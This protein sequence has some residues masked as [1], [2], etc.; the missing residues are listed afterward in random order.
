VIA[1]GVD[2]HK[3][4]H[5]AVALDQ[6]GHVL[7]KWKGAN[8]PRGWGSFL[9]W[10]ASLGPERQVGIEG[11][12]N[13]GRGLAQFLVERGESVF[14]VNSRWTALGR[15]SARSVGKSDVLD[16]NAVA[17]TVVREAGTLPRVTADDVTVIL[18]L[19][20]S[21]RESAIVEA[22]RLRNQI[23]SLLV[24]IDP[25]YE[26]SLPT[27]KTKAGLVAL[28]EYVGPPSGAIGLE[29]AA[30]VRRLAQ[31]LQ[32]ATDQAVFLGRRIR[33][34]NAAD[35]APSERSSRHSSSTLGCASRSCRSACRASPRSWGT[36]SGDSRSGCPSRRR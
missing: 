31:R 26:R 3:R 36:R 5:V 20:V 33:A 23:H 1:V 2:A 30:S 17:T 16:A 25:G 32:L 11:A 29:R 8:D 19:L 6:G 34:S 27:L 28:C 24:L 22:T 21:E 35:R 12:W 9:D 13:L 14:E 18:D 15:R 10:C 7:G 4:L